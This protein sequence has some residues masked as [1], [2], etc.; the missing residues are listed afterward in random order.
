RSSRVAYIAKYA[1]YAPPIERRLSTQFVATHTTLE[2]KLQPKLHDARTARPRDFAVLVIRGTQRA[3]ILAARN[4]KGCRAAAT[5]ID[6]FPLWVI[7]GVECLQPELKSGVFTF[8]PGSLKIL[9]QGKVPVVY[10]RANQ[11]V[12]SHVAEHAALAIGVELRHVGLLDD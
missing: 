1:M 4:A 10:T 6:G 7:E 3:A 5:G 8:E 2:D 9:E 12:A 11:G